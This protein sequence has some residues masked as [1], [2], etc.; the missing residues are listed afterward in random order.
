MPDCP[1]PNAL[2]QRA[3]RYR[4]LL[5][6]LPLLPAIFCTFAEW[7][8]EPGVWGV[9]LTLAALGIAMRVWGIRHCRYS[10]GQANR[11][12]TSGPYAYV[13]NPLYVGNILIIAGAAA[14]SE[15]FWLIPISVLWSLSVFS[16]T[17]RDEERRLLADF[18]ETYRRYREE[19]PAWLPRSTP[20]EASEAPDALIPVLP[21]TLRQTPQFAFLLPFLLK[22]L[23]L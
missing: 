6:G 20:F 8:Y 1:T 4:N 7:E 16:L 11:L 21:V 9:A 14:A 3:Y 10:Y 5:A 17:I 13:R 18:G 19:V 15:L 2:H 23:L 22:E 12:A